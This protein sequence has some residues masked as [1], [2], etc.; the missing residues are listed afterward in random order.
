MNSLCTAKA[1]LIEFSI[2]SHE[3]C[4]KKSQC[5]R[6]LGLDTY[7]GKIFKLQSRIARSLPL[8]VVTNEFIRTLH[9]RTCK[10]LRKH[11]IRK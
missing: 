11:Q 8:T 2:L 10:I 7:T 6:A 4:S 9:P 1:Y 5:K 3:A